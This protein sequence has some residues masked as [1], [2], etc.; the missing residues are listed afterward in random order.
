MNR[1]LVRRGCQRTIFAMHEGRDVGYVFGGVMGTSYR[2]LQFSYDQDYEQLS[3]GSLLQ[4]HQITELCAQGCT[5][6]D[7]GTDLAYKRR[8]SD[9]VMETL[10]LIVGQAP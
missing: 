9:G 4:Y 8:W 3:I 7:L 2:G 6:Y 5:S 10:L 1:R